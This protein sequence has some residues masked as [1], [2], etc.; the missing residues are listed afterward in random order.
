[1][2]VQQSREREKFT[3]AIRIRP[4]IKEDASSYKEAEMEESLEVGDCTHRLTA[5]RF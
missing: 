3:I 4:P 1:M 2:K 5:T